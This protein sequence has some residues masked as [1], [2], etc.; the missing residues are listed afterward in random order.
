[1]SQK[2]Q[3]LS[4]PGILTM[5]KVKDKVQAVAVRRC[6]RLMQFLFPLKEVGWSSE[7]KAAGGGRQAARRKACSQ[8]IPKHGSIVLQHLRKPKDAPTP[9]VTI[10]GIIGR[11]NRAFRERGCGTWWCWDRQFL[12]DHLISSSW[13]SEGSEGNRCLLS[14][15]GRR[16]VAV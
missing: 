14:P 7:G 2:S 12:L 6:Q 13:E 15:P 11:G 10:R 3:A 5:V 1:M 16:C 9:M 8:D 4:V